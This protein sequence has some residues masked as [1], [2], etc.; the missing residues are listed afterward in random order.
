MEAKSEVSEPS[1]VAIVD[2]KAQEEPLRGCRGE[3]VLA[4]KGPR[5]RPWGSE[6]P[7]PNMCRRPLLGLHGGLGRAFSGRAAGGQCT[8]KVLRA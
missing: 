8:A 6:E 3:P 7:V 2:L 4:R 1:E 5:G